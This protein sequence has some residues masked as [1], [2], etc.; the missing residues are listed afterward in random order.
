MD[1]R[2][3]GQTRAPTNPGGLKPIAIPRQDSAIMRQG[4]SGEFLAAPATTLTGKP[5]GFPHVRTI[6]GNLDLPAPPGPDKGTSP[7]QSLPS[8][9]TAAAASILKDTRPQS[10][11]QYVANKLSF[12]PY[13]ARAYNV[14]FYALVVTAVFVLLAIQRA[15]GVV[16]WE[17]MYGLSSAVFNYPMAIAF[18]EQ[19]VKFF[20]GISKKQLS[21]Q[22][23]FAAGLALAVET[24]I[25][26]LAVA[27][28]AVNKVGKD[29]PSSMRFLIYYAMLTFCMNTFATRAVGA[30]NFLHGTYLD[31][32]NLVYKYMLGKG[33]YFNLKDDLDRYWNQVSTQMVL[34]VHSEQSFVEAFYQKLAQNNLAPTR[35]FTE[36]AKQALVFG[37]VNIPRTLAF[38]LLPMWIALAQSGWRTTGNLFGNHK[39]ADNNLLV[40]SS[41]LSS[42]LFYMRGSGTFSTSVAKFQQ[43]FKE[44]LSS[45]FENLSPAFAKGATYFSLA[46]GWGLILFS[47][48]CSGS[49]FAVVMHDQLHPTP[50]TIPANSTDPYAGFGTAAAPL[51]RIVPFE[52]AFQH[53][54]VPMG[55]Y[56]ALTASGIF[57]NGGSFVSFISDCWKIQKENDYSFGQA[58]LKKML[59][60][61][62]KK[63]TP[64]E[65]VVDR[66]DAEDQRGASIVVIEDL[67]ST[68][69]EALRKKVGEAVENCDFSGLSVTTDT[70][71]TARATYCAM[72]TNP[73]PQDQR[74]APLADPLLLGI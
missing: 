5:G 17:L 41:A 28:D 16:A 6:P 50:D 59:G 54:I 4:S 12:L 26:G 30:T 13:V 52:W 34:G 11:S 39:L 58:C 74:V 45:A 55:S 14:I 21:Y 68:Q 62:P 44:H 10:W 73:K 70:V 9:S 29:L 47:A 63:V 60:I 31:A 38:S 22:V 49:G 33:L 2:N 43:G 57:I 35:T 18:N 71:K 64:V 42:W 1:V 23:A 19:L 8:L 46:A 32:R 15:N 53:L 27:Q 69:L 7:M 3:Q 24:T 56:S 67:P 61:E 20:Q 36:R 72:F 40:Y 65:E 25:A 51:F 48:G 66:E 37:A